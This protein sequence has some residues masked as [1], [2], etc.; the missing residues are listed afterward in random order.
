MDMNT[1][2]GKVHFIIFLLR[3]L[4]F[5]TEIKLCQIYFYLLLNYRVCLIN[6]WFPSLSVYRDDLHL[7]IKLCRDFTACFGNNNNNDDLN[8]FVFT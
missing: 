8:N 4:Y 6:Y 1:D 2:F 5:L 3:T 7:V